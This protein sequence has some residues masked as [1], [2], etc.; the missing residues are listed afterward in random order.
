VV[1]F[2]VER[3]QM[4]ASDWIMQRRELKKRRSG[5]SLSNLR[6]FWKLNSLNRRLAAGCFNK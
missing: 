1:V 4:W 5:W 6:G 2:V 3:N